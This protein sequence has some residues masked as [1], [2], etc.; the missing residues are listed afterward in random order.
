MEVPDRGGIDVRNRQRI[1]LGLLGVRFPSYHCP[2]S[3]LTNPAAG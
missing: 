2:C 1:S 3:R